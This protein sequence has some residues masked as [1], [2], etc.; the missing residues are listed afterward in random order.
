MSRSGSA[1]LFGAFVR[2]RALD[3][4]VLAL[5]AVAVAPDSVGAG[6]PRSSELEVDV[7][8]DGDAD[9]DA[10]RREPEPKPLANTVSVAVTRLAAAKAREDC[11]V[12]CLMS[13]GGWLARMVRP[14]GVDCNQCRLYR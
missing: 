13:D 12:Y 11:F 10:I 1:T 6:H 9:A 2:A 3:E 5:V 7:N 8:D 14:V 4:N